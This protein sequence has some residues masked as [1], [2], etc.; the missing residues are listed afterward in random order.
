MHMGSSG[1]LPLAAVAV[2]NFFGGLFLGAQRPTAAPDS[3][4]GCSSQDRCLERLEQGARLRLVLE[5][6][7]GGAVL[8]LLLLGLRASTC[9]CCRRAAARR[10]VPLASP[11]SV[12]AFS[13]APQLAAPTPTVVVPPAPVGAIHLA[14]AAAA[15]SGGADAEPSTYV[16]RRIR[17]KQGA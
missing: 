13:A 8:V 12:Q 6:G 5:L 14:A 9:G 16:P 10:P 2:V 7:L 17:G 3:D 4:G 11:A 1:I 15:G